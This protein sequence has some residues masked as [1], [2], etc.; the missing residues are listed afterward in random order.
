M[1]PD[2]AAPFWS[3]ALRGRC[4]RCGVGKLYQ[5]VLTVRPA[6]PVCNLDLRAVDT[7]DGPAVLVIFILGTVVVGGAFWLEFTFSPPLW[8]HVVV[9]PLVAFPLAIVLIRIMKAGLIA[10]QYRMRRHEMGQ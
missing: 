4:P 10:Q 7:G 9:W 3:V 1:I 5:G 8:V 6:C 2:D